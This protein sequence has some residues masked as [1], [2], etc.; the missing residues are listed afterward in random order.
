MKL[1]CSFHSYVCGCL[2]SLG[3]ARRYSLY[4]LMTNMYT[5][6]CTPHTH[7]H[8]HSHPHTHTLT[9]T[10]THT[11]T[12]T[13]IHTH[14]P[15]SDIAALSSLNLVSNAFSFSFASSAASCFSSSNDSFWRSKELKVL[16][17]KKEED[18]T[19]ELDGF[20]YQTGRK[21]RIEEWRYS[22]KMKVEY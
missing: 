1:S 11:Y 7:T 10:H 14:R 19:I 6:T 20:V 18:I 22:E 5:H 21:W 17:Y 2:Q 8:T 9:S 15:F 16:H 12:H 4:V 3:S 13:Q